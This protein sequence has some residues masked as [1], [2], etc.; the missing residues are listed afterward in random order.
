MV[1]FVL[2]ALLKFYVSSSASDNGHEGI[3]SF[4]GASL[5]DCGLQLPFCCFAPEW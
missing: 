3:K 1:S 5:Y 4:D 2:I